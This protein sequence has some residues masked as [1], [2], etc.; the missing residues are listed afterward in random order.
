MER[1]PPG[2]GQGKESPRLGRTQKSFNQP[3]RRGL[4]LVAHSK[5]FPLQ[6]QALRFNPLVFPS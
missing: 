6:I 1:A 2:E 4:F 3:S 5:A